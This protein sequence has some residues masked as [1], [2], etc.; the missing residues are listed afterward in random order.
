MEKSLN[1]LISEENVLDRNYSLPD[2]KGMISAH[3]LKRKSKEFQ[4][5]VMRKWFF[6]HY[7]NPAERTPYESAEGGY[8]YIWGGPYD[9]YEEL[10]SEFGE[11]ARGNAIKELGNELWSESPEWTNAYDES[12]Y[13]DDYFFET[14]TETKSPIENF[15]QAVSG[16][17]KLLAIEVGG[18]EHFYRLLYGNAI[19][20]LETYLS[21][22]FISHVANNDFFLRKFV[23][24]T[25]E[26]QERKI[27]LSEIFKQ[28]DNMRELVKE[29]L[30]EILWHRIGF[31]EQLF[32]ST[33]E[34]KFP[35]DLSA[36][37]K[38]ISIRHDLVHRNGKTK[39]GVVH[40]ITKSTVE[41][42]LGHVTD[43]V[44]AI[45]KQLPNP[46]SSVTDFDW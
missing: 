20:V 40:D 33:L 46:I 42:V 26:F 27:P 43:I 36:L 30:L 41:E 24:T 14:L 1:K 37:H 18:E 4:K 28:S 22:V 11:I 38:A 32:K 9:A 23:E 21:E 45:E 34:I 31:V 19:T 5:E 12:D 3:G 6:E 2:G 29:H 44:E 13:N 16:I 39:A 7:E 15:D 8:Q 35:A 10:E 25:R 17:K